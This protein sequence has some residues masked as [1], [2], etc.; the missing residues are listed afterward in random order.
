MD[1]VQYSLSCLLLGSKRVKTRKV[2]TQ[3][4]GLSRPYFTDSRLYISVLNLILATFLSYSS[5]KYLI[6]KHEMWCRFISRSVFLNTPIFFKNNRLLRFLILNFSNR[7]NM[8]DLFH[9]DRKGF[10]FSSMT[11]V[12]CTFICVSNMSESTLIKI[13]Q[14]HQNTFFNMRTMR[15]VLVRMLSI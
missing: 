10:S 14:C 8:L 5:I 12:L 3:S 2:S 4:A 13:G 15:P 7:E 6:C 11:L 9:V 1:I